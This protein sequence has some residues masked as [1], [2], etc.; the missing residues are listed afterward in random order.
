MAFLSSTLNVNRPLSPRG[1]GGTGS[2]AVQFSKLLRPF[3]AGN[4]TK[5]L[6]KEM[7]TGYRALSE[8]E[9][10]TLA[11]KI[12]EEVK[13]RGPFLSL[14]DFINRRLIGRDVSRASQVQ[15]SD[16]DDISMA[17]KGALD[18]AI[19]KA[20]I[21][22]E[23][24]ANSSVG[25]ENSYQL[26]EIRDGLPNGTMNDAYVASFPQRK[27]QNMAGWLTQMDILS[28]LAP[29]MT[30]RSDTFKIRVY[31]DCKSP[32]NIQPDA[33]AYLEITVQRQPYFY[34]TTDSANTP[35]TQLYD[36]SGQPDPLPEENTN[37]Q[38]ANRQFGR[39]FEI[40]SLRWLSPNEI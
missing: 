11:E 14:S 28:T 15:F 5:D 1:D 29:A 38:A 22:A 13:L 18:A 2:G 39:K 9:I 33:V 31:G 23:D 19:E 37:L 7:G 16:G 32:N 25:D 26:A 10:R 30:A 20:G 21:N 8:S 24:A 34:D 27:S 36:S 40:V 6:S 4:P 12:V 35:V 3:V 17:L